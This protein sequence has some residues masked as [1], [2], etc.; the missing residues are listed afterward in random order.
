MVIFSYDTKGPVFLLKAEDRDTLVHIGRY[1]EASDIEQLV[2]VDLSVDEGDT[3]KIIVLQLPQINL[4][5][6]TGN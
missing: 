1:D 3:H 2:N 4:K 5:R 6:K